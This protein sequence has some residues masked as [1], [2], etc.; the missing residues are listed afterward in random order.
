ML[1]ILIVSAH[2][3]D[4]ETG[5]GG[6]ALRLKQAG[7]RLE[8]FVTTRAPKDKIYEP[9][10]RSIREVRM[11]ESYKSHELL[12]ITPL[13]LDF[14]EGN[15]RMDKATREIFGEK[16]RSL[17]PDVV[18]VHWPVDVNPDHRQ[19]AA[20]TIE[21]FMQK[22]MNTEVFCYEVFSEVGRPQSL[23][24]YPTHYVDITDVLETKKEMVYCM[25]S[26]GADALWAGNIEM[27]TNRGKEVG[28]FPTEAF[29]RITRY[30][31]LHPEL[32][33]IF[34]STRFELPMSMG[35]DVD[36]A[37]IGLSVTA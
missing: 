37:K 13:F 9:E 26:Q 19:V 20:L 4:L 29:V 14:E 12:G 27:Q 1:K 22:G 21:A 24:F 6:T 15:P 30:G 11:D 23:G 18:F 25:K 32:T 36:P 10:G 5:M 34:Q 16:V 3:D 2:E 33:K 31:D 8:S 35:I 28:L 7:H 17:E